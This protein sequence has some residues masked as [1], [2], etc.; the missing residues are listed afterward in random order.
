MEGG[1]ANNQS[2]EHSEDDGKVLTLKIEK[3]KIVRARK[4]KKKQKSRHST[5]SAHVVFA[6]GDKE[7]AERSIWGS[8]G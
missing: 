5:L 3:V 4:M 7:C 8:H 6:T 1:I 2:E